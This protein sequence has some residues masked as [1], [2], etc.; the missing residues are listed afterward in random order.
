MKIVLLTSS[1]GSGGAERVA[2]TLCN[3]WSSRGDSVTLI[4]TFSGGGKPFY[5]LSEQVELIYLASR[6]Q[7][8]SRGFSS[9]KERLFTL[10]R[11]IAERTPD[12]VISFLPNVNVAAVL[13]TLGMK[14]PV[15][16]CERSDPSRQPYRPLWK[17]ACQLTYRFADMLTVQ[18]ASVAESAAAL[19]P[20]VRKIRTV[21]NPLPSAV[22]EHTRAT[23]SERRI[24]LSLGRLSPEKQVD[25]IIEA[26]SRVCNAHPDWDLH[27]YGDGPLH[28]ELDEHVSQRGL[29]QR[30]LLKGRTSNPW[31]VMAEADVFVM[32][33]L[34]EGFPNAL[35]EAMGVGLPCI[36]FDCPSGPREISNDG[37]N[38]ILVPLNDQAGLSAAMEK[39]MSNDSLQHMLG[40]QANRAVLERFSLAAVLSRWDDLFKEVGAI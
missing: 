5:S 13:A 18:T 36:A 14:V 3:Q 32:A 28:D 15:I 37:Q 27:I 26:F 34:Y 6:V 25:R 22:L 39:L 11:L 12:V 4:P 24:L 31:R 2:T 30:I 19:F 35:L 8:H 23:K 1:L 16:I 7:G 33:S 9:Y 29:Q 10:R 20:S 40:G 17:F 21:A 38:A